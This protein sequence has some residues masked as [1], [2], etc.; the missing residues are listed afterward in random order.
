[1]R[2]E[3]YHDGSRVRVTTVHMPA[4]NTPQFRWVKSRLPNK[5]QPVPPIFQPEVAAE[6]I[7]FGVDHDRREILVGWPTMKAVWGN[8]FFPAY[9]DRRLGRNGYKAQQTSEPRNPERPDNLWHPVD[10]AE[11]HGAHGAFDGRATDF[12]M[13][14]WLDL[15]RGL[16]G[17]TAAAVVAAACWLA[18]V[19]WKIS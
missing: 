11:D 9:A 16:V 7:L 13:G 3:L 1:M 8:Q 6:A 19:V 4:L 14:L 5:G 15:H 10:E 18:L 2:A 12:S 17:R